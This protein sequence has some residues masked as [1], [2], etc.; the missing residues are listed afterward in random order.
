[1]NIGDRAYSSQCLLGTQCLGVLT[2]MHDLNQT[3]RECNSYVCHRLA[4]LEEPLDIFV[5]LMKKSQINPR[6]HYLTFPRRTREAGGDGMITEQSKRQCHS[7]TS[8]QQ[9]LTRFLSRIEMSYEDLLECASKEMV[10]AFES[11]LRM[12]L[13]L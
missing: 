9:L 6:S 11:V 4:M 5:F 3:W 7:G 12:R 10:Q 2:T 1:M 8:T 13:G